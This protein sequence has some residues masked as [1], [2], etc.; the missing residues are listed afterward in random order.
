MLKEK[1]KE[2]K[3]FPG[4]E[5]SNLGNVRCF[6]NSQ[7]K[8][9]KNFRI[10]KPLLNKDGYY[11]VD[12]YNNRKQH[13]K[14]IHRLVLNAF[15]GEQPNL[16]A[17]HINGNKLDNKLS[18]LEWVTPKDNSTL[19]SKQGL[20][21]TKPIQIIETGETY[22]SIKDCAKAIH[23]DP[24]DISN[25][26]SKRKGDNIKGLHFKLLTEEEYKKMKVETTDFLYE[27]QRKAIN[28][29]RNGCILNGGVGSGKSRTGLYYYFK[30]QGGKITDKY[31]PMQ[32][33]KDLYIITT[34]MK[35]DTLEWEGELVPFLLSVHED[36]NYYDNKIIIDSWN[37]IKK[38]SDIR[39]AFFI[40]DEQ[41][42]VGSGAWVKAFLKITKSNDWIL[43]TATA[44]DTWADYIPVF[45]ANGFYKNRS[46]FNREHVVYSRFSKYPKIDRYLNTGRLIRLRNRIL[47]DMDFNRGTIPHHED[48][49]CSYNMLLYKQVMKTR[50]D[51]YKNEPI[52]QASGL[53]YILRR[54][55][56]EDQSRQVALLEIF[57]KHPKLIIFYNFDYELNILKDIFTGFVNDNFEIG[58]WNGHKHQPVPKSKSWVYLVQYTAGAE[59]WN[60]IKTDTIVFYSQS[61][62]YRATQQA[63]GRIDRLNTPFKDL[64]YYH[65]KSRSGIDLAIS[66]ALSQKKNFNEGKFIKW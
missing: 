25:C 46:E 21:K 20:Y 62:S 50:W 66:K 43:L 51:I 22:S 41:R 14:R 11:Y 60:C 8:I 58:E 53:C 19:A 63:S 36:Y 12:L 37:N 24:A 40:F 45:I 23:V 42:V 13:H 17:N 2:I 38:Y 34:A 18:N 52:Q 5:V 4:Y 6:R 30:E 59:G 35:R 44:G 54:I 31:V 64:Y 27:Y 15:V 29:M 57:E 55:V 10:L 7:G 61:Y 9:T 47:V 49:Y 33:P 1:W 26:L 39:D 16:V 56:N 65:F 3:E 28:N 32:N 48:V